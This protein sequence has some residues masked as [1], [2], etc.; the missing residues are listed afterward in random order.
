MP[1]PYRNPG[2]TN[3]A[4][5]DRTR[6]FIIEASTS[7]REPRPDWREILRDVALDLDKIAYGP[8]A[9][10]DS[11]MNAVLAMGSL[12]GVWLDADEKDDLYLGGADA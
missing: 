9:H 4:A 10:P 7:G 6:D 8:D 11:V 2:P 3:E 5:F 12:A 1:E